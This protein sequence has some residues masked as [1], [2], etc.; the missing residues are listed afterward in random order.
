MDTYKVQKGDTLISIARKIY[1]NP[2]KWKELADLNG[3]SPNSGLSIGQILH[4]LPQA[5]VTVSLPT[6]P[7]APVK[8]IEE[9]QTEADGS[10]EIT[11]DGKKYF[12]RL[13]G[14]L[15]TIVLGEM[16]EKGLQRTGTFQAAKFIST[17]DRL[18]DGLKLTSSEKNCIL[19]VSQL[20]GNPD[21]INTWDSAFLSWGIFQ[22][23]LGQGNGPGELPALLKLIKTVNPKL[24]QKFFGL[25][26]LD[27]SS[28]T[29]DT[30]GY[31]NYKGDEI[32]D[33]YKKEQFRSAEW[34]VRFVLAGQDPEI[35]ALQVLFAIRRLDL[36]YYKP[37]NE[38]AGKSLSQIL[39]SEYAVAL[40][41]DNHV[42][43]PAFVIPIIKKAIVE[44]G[45]NINGELDTETQL[46]IIDKYLQDRV[47]FI[48]KQGQKPMTKPSARA[49]G[50]L[51]HVNS[52]KLSKEANSFQSGK[53]NR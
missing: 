25:F 53:S 16:R 36:F 42:N 20:E 50:I 19:A 15:N 5:G 24:F 37:T 41:L 32:T 34:S 21:G 46:K 13:K 45:I 35:A 47:T 52:G 44:L 6:Q 49:S 4:L 1:G 43:R 7:P 31:L 9:N 48:M 8:N 2:S 38:F 18:L 39:T 26:G 29:N 3:I 10:V 12:Y 27:I 17:N 28:R 23:T 22:W 33:I 14:S 51:G 30:I 40:L 11:K